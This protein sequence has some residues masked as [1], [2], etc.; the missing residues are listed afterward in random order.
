MSATDKEIELL[1]LQLELLKTK[2]ELA[3]TRENDDIATITELRRKLDEP[4]PLV[5]RNIPTKGQIT[6]EMLE[7]LSPGELFILAKQ[8]GVD[9][10]NIFPI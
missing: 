1:K 5:A 4:V 10:R 6:R 2:L 3:K 8:K 9:I 7:K